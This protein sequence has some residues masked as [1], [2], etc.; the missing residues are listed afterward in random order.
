M[1][2][3][4]MENSWSSINES[5][6]KRVEVELQIK[7]PESYKTFLLKYNGGRPS[8]N[9]FPIHGDSADNQG[10][11]D[12]FLCIQEGSHYDITWEMEMY[13]GRIP[14]NF[15]I[16]G[17][18]PGSN[19][20]CLSISGDEYGKVFFWDHENEVAEGEEPDYQNVYLIANS[21]D[22]FLKSLKDE[23]AL[24]SQI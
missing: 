3:I 20:I 16:I 21:F 13:D 11:L 4:T 9:I 22:E 15:L 7:F 14:R 6:I 5:E 2:A 23:S 18:D 1:V 12:W 10:I 8:P 19:N 24:S 17:K